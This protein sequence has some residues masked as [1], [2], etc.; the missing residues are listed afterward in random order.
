MLRVRS[1]PTL[2]DYAG[3]VTDEASVLSR[4]VQLSQMSMRRGTDF[5][6]FQ[7]LRLLGGDESE[8]SL[9]AP[10]CGTPRR[11]WRS[12]PGGRLPRLA[13]WAHM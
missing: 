9:D 4:L 6:Q 3:A 2:D 7:P 8:E 5:K 11:A 10:E 12:G 13:W 1:E